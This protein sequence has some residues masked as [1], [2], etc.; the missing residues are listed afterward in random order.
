MENAD[1]ERGTVLLLEAPA[2]Y[3]VCSKL[4]KNSIC[5]AIFFIAASFSGQST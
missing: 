4:E 1:G 3:P 5:R 2:N